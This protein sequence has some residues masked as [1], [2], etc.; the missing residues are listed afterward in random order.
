MQPYVEPSGT[1]GV[2][3]VFN[4]LVKRQLCTHENA[5]QAGVLLAILAERAD[6]CSQALH[7]EGSGD[8][9]NEGVHGSVAVAA[10]HYDGST[11]GFA[12]RVKEGINKV[13]EISHRVGIGGIVNPVRRGSEGVSQFVKREVLHNQESKELEE[14]WL[15]AIYIF[16]HELPRIVTNYH[17]LF[18][19][20]EMDNFQ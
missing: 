8:T 20:A 11:E 15:R 7:M 10:L 3:V 13:V 17:E 19:A 2:D 4:K 6:V 9:V 12:Q 16:E 1:E 18:I 14:F 5:Y